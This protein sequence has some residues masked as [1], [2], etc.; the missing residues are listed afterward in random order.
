MG[1]NVGPRSGWWR[2]ITVTVD[3]ARHHTPHAFWGVIS[4]AIVPRLCC[5]DPSLGPRCR[6][7][8]QPKA[9][10]FDQVG[11]CISQTAGAWRLSLGHWPLPRGGGL[12]AKKNGICQRNAEPDRIKVISP[13]SSA[14]RSLPEGTDPM[15]PAEWMAR[16]ARVG[17]RGRGRGAPCRICSSL[18]TRIDPSD[19]QWKQGIS[20][21]AR[22]TVEGEGVHPAIR[23]KVQDPKPGVFEPFLDP[24]S[25]PHYPPHPT[26][27]I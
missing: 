11:R 19:M 12:K 13:I 10:A 1:T 9:F 23:W 21:G 14:N 7:Q 2:A 22:W 8:R 3:S 16:P 24:Q 27:R 18:G 25:N 6:R 26:V 17:G 15:R 20:F 5:G 4:T